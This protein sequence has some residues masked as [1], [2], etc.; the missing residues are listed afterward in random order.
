MKRLLCF[1]FLAA[2]NGP[3]KITDAPNTTPTPQSIQVV[4][5]AATMHA[6]RFQLEAQVGTA[7]PTAPASDGKRMLQAEAPRR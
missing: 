4:S 5:G 3:G 7:L 1:L 6:G 2:C